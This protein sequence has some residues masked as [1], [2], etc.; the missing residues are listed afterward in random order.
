MPWL[1]RLILSMF[2]VLC[3]GATIVEQDPYLIYLDDLWTPTANGQNI[4]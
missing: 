2:H 4:K 3:L 1:D